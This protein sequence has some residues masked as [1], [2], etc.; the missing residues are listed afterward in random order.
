MIPVALIP[1]AVH[2]LTKLIDYGFKQADAIS[3]PTKKKV[4]MDKI[5]LNKQKRE[6][7]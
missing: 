6:T 4:V 2:F 5:E 7:K 3:D 1:V